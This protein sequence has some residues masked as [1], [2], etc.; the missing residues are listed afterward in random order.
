METGN[1]LESDN[2]LEFMPAEGASKIGSTSMY[3]GTDNIQTTID[4]FDNENEIQWS[5]E[6]EIGQPNQPTCKGDESV[7]SEVKSTPKKEMPYRRTGCKAH[8]RAR[9]V[10]QGK[11]VVSKFHNEHNHELIVS[12]SKSRFGRSHRKITK[13][14][15][16]IIHRLSDKRGRTTNIHFTRKDL[17]NEV[18]EKN[19]RLLGIDV[20][21]ALNYFRELQKD[22][23][24][25]KNKDGEAHLWSYDPIERQARDIYTK[26][27]FFEFRKHLRAATAYSILE[28]EKNTLYKISP[29]AQCNIQ[30][31]RLR[32]YMVSVDVPNQKVSCNCKLFEFFGILCSHCLK[33]LPYLNMHSIP[34]HYILKRWTKD[35]KRG[36]TQNKDPPQ[37]QCKGKRRPQRFKPPVEKK[38]KKSRTC[39]LCRKKG[40]NR[41]TCKETSNIS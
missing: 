20:S 27:I 13:D 9:M 8:I 24:D 6:P 12:P 2:Q 39:Q 11:W 25:F 3:F 18:S 7:A 10:E 38:A 33:V 35:A 16:E 29:L 15:R 40:H 28:L 14:Q 37:S 41:R 31:R 23:E 5:H 22:E 26:A 17:M 36:T 1:S 21:S 34:A 4:T 32:S 19:R 30:N